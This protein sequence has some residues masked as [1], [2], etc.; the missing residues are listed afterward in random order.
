MLLITIYKKNFA[1]CVLQHHLAAPQAPSYCF[2]SFTFNTADLLV[3]ITRNVR[4]T[5]VPNH[6]SRHF[7]LR[8]RAPSVQ[9]MLVIS[10]ALFGA[11]RR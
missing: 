3:A 8:P 10:N 6:S 7:R 4:S 1:H 9:L 11:L 5:L 2:L